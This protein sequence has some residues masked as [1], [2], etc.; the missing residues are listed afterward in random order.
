[1]RT[2][3][4]GD[5][6]GCSRALD[7]LLDRVQLQADD[8]VVTLGDYV[9]RGPDSAGVIERLIQL[10]RD[11]RL[12]PLR[13]NHEI[14]MLDARQSDDAVRLALWLQYGGKETLASYAHSTFAADQ[15]AQVPEHHWAFL[16]SCQGWHETETHFFVHANAYPFLPLAEQPD[17]ILYWEPFLDLG[18]HESGK[19]MVCG[20]T[21]QKS[22]VPLCRGHAICIDTWVYGDGWLTCYDPG[23][24]RIWQANQRGACRTALLDDVANR[25]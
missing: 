18:P 1:M 6:H 11:C 20:H 2:L 14:M 17:S 21:A 23:S 19:V 13:G 7:L 4:I 10:R 9:D 25:E 5:I 15:L 12:V 8:Q 16:Q 24:G 3:A 22:G